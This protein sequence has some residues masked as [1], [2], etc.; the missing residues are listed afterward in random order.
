[1]PPASQYWQHQLVNSKKGQSVP[2]YPHS[3]RDPRIYLRK[4]ADVSLALSILKN[5]TWK[6]RQ[7][8][9]KKTTGCLLN[10][11]TVNTRLNG[12]VY[13]NNFL[14]LE[15]G[16]EKMLH[17]KCIFISFQDVSY[18]SKNVFFMANFMGSYSKDVRHT[19][20]LTLERLSRIS[21]LHR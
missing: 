9:K 8:K 16:N 17:S 6:C 15:K 10:K 14:R 3:S 1:M 20:L 13:Q 2:V 5:G 7:K 18:M 21:L 4:P 19:Y 11:P 12:R